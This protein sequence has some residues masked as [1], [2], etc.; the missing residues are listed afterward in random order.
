MERNSK[1][2]Y[3]TYI[4]TVCCR[5]MKF[6]FGFRLTTKID[7]LSRKFKHNWSCCLIREQMDKKLKHMAE[8]LKGV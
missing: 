4:L 2:S 7:S 5:F 8:V 3:S 6:L 1:M